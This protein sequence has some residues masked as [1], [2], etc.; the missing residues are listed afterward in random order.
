MIAEP[1]P[2]KYAVTRDQIEKFILAQ[3]PGREIRFRE[4][5]CIDNC[6]CLMVQY[7]NDSG[8]KNF[9][10]TN[11]KWLGTDMSTDEWTYETWGTSHRTYETLQQEVL[12]QRSN[13]D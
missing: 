4:C 2:S 10:C 9:I 8:F 5:S 13:D 12:K 1:E 7:G 3:D 6:G 11:N